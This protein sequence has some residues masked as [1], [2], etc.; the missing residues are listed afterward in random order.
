MTIRGLAG[1]LLLCLAFGPLGGADAQNA[2]PQLFPQGE[3]VFPASSNPPA[4]KTIEINSAFI[5]N[6]RPSELIQGSKAPAQNNASLRIPAPI[7]VRTNVILFRPAVL[8]NAPV[9]G[10]LIPPLVSTPLATTPDQITKLFETPQSIACV[11]GLIPQ[12]AGCNPNDPTLRATK[13]SGGQKTIAVITA[14]D[15]PNIKDNFVAFSNFF[16]LPSEGLEIVYASEP[17]ADPVPADERGWEVETY[18]DVQWVHALA[19][20]AKIKLVIAKSSKPDD[21]LTAVA[22]ASKQIGSAGGG[23]IVMSWTVPLLDFVKATNWSAKQFDLFEQNVFQRGNIV[24]VAATGDFP[25]VGYPASSSRVVAVG[26]TSLVRD[27]KTNQFSK[28]VAWECTGAGLR[29]DVQQPSYQSKITPNGGRSIA[30]IAAASD[31]RMGAMVYVGDVKAPDKSWLIIDK[32]WM[33]VGG[34]S[35]AAPIVAGLINQSGKFR[36]SGVKQL[37]T[38]YANKKADGN[39]SDIDIGQCGPMVKQTVDCCDP[40]NQSNSCCNSK[41]PKFNSDACMKRDTTRKFS[42]K[43]GWDYCT[44]MGSPKGK[45]GL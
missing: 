17:K 40:K 24:P 19:P 42:A 10:Y 7:R 13:L 18:L 29:P 31:P 44:G 37:T 15:V 26:G 43:A 45:D 23:E 12:V 1:S 30:D 22:E 21:M 4:A 16:G 39:F 28:E 35:L 8:S 20:D 33:V 14:Y 11:Y 25:V 27:Q 3:F 36:A 6:M 34:T 38:L 9:V 2:S 5:S 32:A 41:D